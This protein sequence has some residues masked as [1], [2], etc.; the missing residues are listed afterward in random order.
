MDE[1]FH[2][3]LQNEY[4]LCINLKRIG[5][6]LKANKF[7]RGYYL[8]EQ[9]KELN[10]EFFQAGK[11]VCRLPCQFSFKTNS[12]DI[13]SCSIYNSLTLPVKFVFNPID[14]SGE[15]YYSIYKIGDDLRVSYLFFKKL[16]ISWFG[17]FCVVARSNCFTIIILYG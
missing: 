13:N 12:I 2:N 11:R 7:N 9:V 16:F 17:V 10:N 1:N 14:L 15:K 5:S 3:E 4:D 6:E 8:I